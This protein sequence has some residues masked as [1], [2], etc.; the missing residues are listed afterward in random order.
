MPLTQD[1][2]S[3]CKKFNAPYWAAQLNLFEAIR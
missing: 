2:Y 1:M 3:L